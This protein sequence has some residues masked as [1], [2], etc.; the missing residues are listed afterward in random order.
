[1]YNNKAVLALFCK[2]G[3][4]VMFSIQESHVHKGH[5]WPNKISIT[6]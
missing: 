4:I 3:V 6:Y 5:M 1:M 2:S